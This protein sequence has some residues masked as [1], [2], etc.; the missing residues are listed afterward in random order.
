MN[1]IAEERT[2][3]AAKMGAE[4]IPG[5]LESVCKAMPKTRDCLRCH[6]GTLNGSRGE[7]V[8]TNCDKFERLSFKRVSDVKEAA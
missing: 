3:A 2:F 4:V 8:I 6:I 5:L 7:C 1:S